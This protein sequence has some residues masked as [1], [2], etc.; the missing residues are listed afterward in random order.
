MEQK[1]ESIKEDLLN[2]KSRDQ[3]IKLEA[4]VRELQ[5]EAQGKPIE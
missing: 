4:K 1:Y 3:E 2:E 5:R